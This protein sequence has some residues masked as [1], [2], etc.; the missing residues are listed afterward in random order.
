MKLFTLVASLLASLSF[1][2]NAQTSDRTPADDAAWMLNRL[3]GVRNPGD[4]PL[5]QQMATLIS[6]GDR[7]A[8]AAIATAQP[9]FYSV[10]VKEMAAQ[11]STREETVAVPLNDFVASFIGVT[12]D[13]TD[14]RELLYGDFYYAADPGKITGA[15]PAIPNNL[16]T[17]LLLSNN[18]FV[19]L[20]RSNLD[21]GA[22][23]MRINGQKIATANDANIANPDPAGV[24]TSHSF[25][26]AHAIAGTNRRLVEFSLREFTCTPIIGAADTGAPDVRIGRDIERSPGG[27][28][29]KF[30][31]NCK[32]CHTIMDGFRGAFA[33]WDFVN[34]VGNGANN[35]GAAIYVDN[36]VTTGNFQPRVDTN[37]NDNARGVVFKMNRPDFVQYSGGY[38]SR[39][40]S[41]INNAV[42]GV[43]ATR[44]GWRGLAPDASAL[45][46]NTGGAHTFGRLIAN[47]EQFSRCMA[48]RV[49]A[50]VCRYDVQDAD[51]D[52]IYA[53][54]AMDFEQN[55][56]ALKT[57]FHAV[58]A[59]PRCRL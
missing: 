26:G 37:G 17:D 21:I 25:L 56:Y 51:G 8:A 11:M 54:L 58:A 24:I 33:K 23:L 44:F 20:E 35:P 22:A 34:N 30:Q 47:S 13:G 57:L 52:A 43:N 3:T 29:I 10:T 55:N 16:N 19:G 45:A 31:N 6:N 5:I 49:F 42:R 18:H 36:G 9:Q 14:A 41:F 2:L 12:R 32:G 39:D 1:N 59:H 46:S 27:D 48:K 7:K 53:S 38:I 15:T 50:Q 4:S 40:D 28:P